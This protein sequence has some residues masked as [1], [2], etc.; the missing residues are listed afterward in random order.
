VGGVDELIAL[1]RRINDLAVEQVEADGE[2]AAMYFLRT[3]D[4][5]VRPRLF[6]RPERSDELA[7][8]AGASSADAV[9][10][11]AETTT[12]SLLVA[13]LDRRGHQLVLETKLE[14]RDDGTV[15][16]LATTADELVVPTLDGVRGVWEL[17][18]RL[19]F[20]GGA[21]CAEVPSGWSAA[22]DGDVVELEPPSR[23]GAAHFS[24][25]AR[26]GDG[27]AAALVRRFADGRG[28]GDAEISK[29]GAGGAET[30]FED[31]DGHYWLVATWVTPTRAVLFTYNDDG[32]DDEARAEAR[33][34]LESVVVR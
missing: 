18:R 7:R 21:F 17:P 9:V 14:R 34:V 11:V 22:E 4:G 33:A 3:P 32:G 27:E 13:G 24:V 12:D 23:A 30:A 15:K 6:R 19:P 25:L 26:P 29:R 16:A 8:A 20:F 28:A 1:V 31:R 5:G 10:I 2:H